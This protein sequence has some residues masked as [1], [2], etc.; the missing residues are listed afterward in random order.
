MIQQTSLEAYNI[1]TDEK[2]SERYKQILLAIKH[3]GAATNMEIAQH[4]GWSIN[5]VTPRVNELIKIGKMREFYDL[6]GKLI[7][8]ECKVTGYKARVVGLR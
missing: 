7:S 3:L 8:R 6:E 1:L 5:R 2:L 4:L